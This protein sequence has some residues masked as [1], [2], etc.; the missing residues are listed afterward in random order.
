LGY[1][2]DLDEWKDYDI[3]PAVDRDWGCNIPLLTPCQLPSTIHI[4]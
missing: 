4:S 3:Q 2:A 1:G